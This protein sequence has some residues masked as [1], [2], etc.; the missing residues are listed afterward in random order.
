M[1]AFAGTRCWKANYHKANKADSVQEDEWLGRSADKSF[2]KVLCE[3]ECMCLC[4]SATGCKAFDFSR[5]DKTAKCPMATMTEKD[6]KC[7]CKPPF[8]LGAKGDCEGLAKEV[9]VTSVM[10]ATCQ[11]RCAPSRPSRPPS[12]PP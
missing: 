7:A 1:P 9:I 11:R 12:S 4:T 6:W 3:D 10:K 8:R 2:P 5:T